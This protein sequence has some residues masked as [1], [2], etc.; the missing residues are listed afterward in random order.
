MNIT[1]ERVRELFKYNPNTGVVRWIKKSHPKSTISIGNIAGTN[2]YSGYRII[3]IDRKIY[4]LHRII[5][6]FVYGYFPEEMIDHRDRN[7]SNNRLYNLREA[8]NQCNQR[9]S[10]VSA[11]N[12]SGIKGV[13]WD[14]GS[15]KWHSYIK[16]NG[17]N[18]NLGY[19]I[20]FNNA[21]KARWEAEIKYDWSDCNTTS[22]AY[23]YLKENNLL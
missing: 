2:H 8:T 13:C 5:W 9:N 19:T 3:K 21:V 23:L 16:I 12:K 11:L 14:K 6:L 15:D 1:Y 22:S 7:R 20:N 4:Q 17:K 18:D 10:K